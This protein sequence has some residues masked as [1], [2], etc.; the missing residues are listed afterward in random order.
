MESQLPGERQRRDAWYAERFGATALPPYAFVYDGRPSS[1][2]LASWQ[3]TQETLQQ[4]ERT[5]TRFVRSDPKTGIVVRCDCEV[6]DD[7]PAVEWVVSIENTGASDTPLIEDVQALDATLLG[8]TRGDV[9]LHRALGSNAARSDFAPVAEALAPGSVVRLAPVGGRS[10]NTVALPFFN[11]EG[12][13]EGVVM[14]IGWS[15]QWAASW[16]RGHGVRVTAGVERTHLRLRPG[17]TIR[18]PRILLLFWEGDD[19]LRGNNRFRRLVLAHRCPR[20]DG[21]PLLGPLAATGSPGIDAEFNAA[22]VLNQLA[23]AERYRQFG[24]SPEYWWIDAGWYEGRWPNGVG[25]WFP[26]ADGFPNG[27]RPVSDGVRAMGYK[28][29]L[30]WFEPE[31]VHQGTWLDREHPEWVLKL[32]NHAN[33]LLDLGNPDAL[34]WLTEHVSGMIETEGI[35]FFRQDFNMDPLPY[36]RAHDEPGR[37][38]IHEI[39]HVE[40]LYAFWDAL[41]ERHPGLQIDNCSSGGRRIDLETTWRSV[42]LWR[43]DYQYFEPNGYQCHTYGLNHYIPLSGTGSGHPDVYA[44]RSGMNSAIVLGWYLWDRNFP[45]ELGKRCLDE[46]LRLRHLYL[47]DFYPLTPHST[48]DDV[49]I[50]YQFHR[51]DLGEGMAL[52]FRRVNNGERSLGLKLRGLKPDAMYEVHLEESVSTCTGAALEA[53]YEVVAETAPGS[54]LVHYIESQ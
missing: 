11:L 13:G 36:W 49:W 37:Q 38:G 46:Y 7:F 2:F 48:S 6:F 21:Q 33:G 3:A 19:E 18:T 24:Y 34:R 31:R 30:L 53:G 15:G 52:A 42:P 22:T 14:A 9:V 54:V 47:G 29:L 20:K 5:L 28:G 51:D 4:G 27:L 10:S 40:G 26:R 8:D 16:S 41:A 44:F 12:D 25:N 17:E 1:E 39:R 50:A 35:A 43:T 45:I 32:P 23:S